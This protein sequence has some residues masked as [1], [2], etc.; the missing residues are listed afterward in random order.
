MTNRKAR[1]AKTCNRIREFLGR[2]AKSKLIRAKSSKILI[3]ITTR[4]GNEG[5]KRK[6]IKGSVINM[7]TR[8]DPA[9]VVETT[10][11]IGLI[12]S[13]IIPVE[14]KIGK[15]AQMVVVV[16]VKIAIIKSR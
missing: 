4:L 7:A 15:K 6:R 13:P 11:G 2:I 9:R 8:N 12:N 16:V 3:R 1:K 5:F 14:I 10:I